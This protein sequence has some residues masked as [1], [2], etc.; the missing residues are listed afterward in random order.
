MLRSDE[1]GPGTLTGVERGFEGEAAPWDEDTPIARKITAYDLDALRV[2]LLDITV[3]EG[4]TGGETLAVSDLVTLGGDGKWYKTSGSVGPKTRGPIG[5]VIDPAGLIVQVE[6]SVTNPAWSFLPGA[7][8][9]VGSD[10][11]KVSTTPGSFVSSIGFAISSTRIYL[12]KDPGGKTGMIGIKIFSQSINRLVIGV[13]IVFS[14]IVHAPYTV[15]SYDWDFDD[16]S[17]HSTEKAPEHVYLTP[18][19]YDVC[20]TVTDSEDYTHKAHYVLNIAD[21][22]TLLLQGTV[23]Q[24]VPLTKT[25][26]QVSRGITNFQE[27]LPLHDPIAGRTSYVVFQNHGNFKGDL[28]QTCPMTSTSYSVGVV[29]DQ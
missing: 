4:Q 12:K 13:P 22:M 8:L 21:K 24:E 25:S 26:Y 15:V 3:L 5:V 10:S 19:D 16:G 28:P 11:G 2:N 27:G 18:G 9:Y 7:K 6:G 17:A 14:A 29:N 23:P 1:T 20:L